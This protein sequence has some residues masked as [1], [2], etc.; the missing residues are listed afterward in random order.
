MLILP[1]RDLPGW[2]L[3][4]AGA[5]VFTMLVVIWFTSAYWFFSTF[6]IKR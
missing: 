5:V 3:P 6:G 4:V 1:K 2:V